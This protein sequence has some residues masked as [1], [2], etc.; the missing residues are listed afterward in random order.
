MAQAQHSPAKCCNSGAEL[1]FELISNRAAFDALEAEWNALFARAG[2]PTQLFQ[3]FNW[4]WHWANHFLGSS[5]G[6]I[7]GVDLCTIVAHRAGKLV[8]VWPLV[9]ERVRGLTQIFWMGEPVSQYGDVLIDE[10]SDQFEILLAAWEFLKANLKGDLL[11]LRRVRA[12]A[13]IAP[14]LAYIGAT[15]SNRQVAPFLDLADAT[16]FT[17]YEE[18]F[19]AKS[20]RNRRRLS[21][22]LDDDKSVEFKRHAGGA[23]AAERAKTALNL[24]AAWLADKG[25]VSQTIGGKRMSRFFAD[26]AAAKTHPA[27]CIIAELKVGDEPAALEILLSCKGRVAVHVMAH[28]IALENAGVGV[29]LLEQSVRDAFR[30][31]AMTVDLLAPG[32]DYKRDWADASVEV[33]DWCRPLSFAGRTYSRLYLNLVRDHVEAALNSMPASLRRL[34]AG[35][36]H[37]T[38]RP[39]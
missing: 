32:A 13:A 29:L 6:G 38:N 24:K 23:L 16:D 27:G 2:L 9:S 20:R 22:R 31:G 17:S 15:A 14:L 33:E 5:A 28:D 30:E 39:H 4:N 21:R 34:A 18:R 10:S 8:F 3:T 7:R 1:R 12:D 25:L 19:S 36:R 26:V 35:A 11:R 37:L